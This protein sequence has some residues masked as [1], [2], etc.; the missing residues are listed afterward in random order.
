MVNFDKQNILNNIPGAVVVYKADATGEILYANKALIEL[1]ECKD[2][3]DFLNATN[4]SFRSAIVPDEL[5]Y[6][7]SNIERQMAQNRKKYDHIFFHILTK[8]S[9]AVYVEGYGKMVEDEEHGEVYYAF[10]AIPEVRAQYG[11][12]DSLTGLLNR[13]AFLEKSKRCEGS[14]HAVLYLDIRG[15]KLINQYYGSENGDNFLRKTAEVLERTFSDALIARFAAD[16]FVILCDDND[17]EGKI[18]KAYDRVLKLEESLKLKLDVGVY[19]S[20]N[21]EDINME[22]DYAKMACDSI[23]KDESKY[24]AYYTEALKKET[25]FHKYIADHIDDAIAN[26]HIQIYYQPVIRTMSGKLCG[27]EALARWIDPDLGLISPANF[28]PVLE[29][30]NI[31]YKLDMYVIEQVMEHLCS[32]RDAGKEVIPVSLNISR[33]DFDMFSP[34]EM[35]E[36]L[37]RKHRLL[38]EWVHIEV[39]ES[40]I[41][42]N[43]TMIKSEILKLREGGYEVWLDDFG[44][45]Y[46]SLNSLKDYPVDEIKFDMVFL[47]NFNERAKVILTSAVGM[48]KEL[49]IHTLAEGVETQEQFDFLKSIGCEKIQGYLYGRPEPYDDMMTAIQEKSIFEETPE[50]RNYYEKIG[51]TNIITDASIAVFDY[52]GSKFKTLYRSRNFGIVDNADNPDV[53]NGIDWIMNYDESPLRNAIRNLAEKA[54][55][56]GK[57]E[58]LDCVFSGRYYRAT[59]ECIASKNKGIA[60]L[61][62]LTDIT[63]KD[64]EEVNTEFN[65]VSRNIMN[66]FDTICVVNRTKR[67]I[68]AIRTEDASIPIGEEFPIEKSG[69]TRL[70]PLEKLYDPDRINLY[71]LLELTGEK[72]DTQRGVRSRFFRL[73]NEQGN[74]V[75][76]ESITFPITVPREASSAGDSVLLLCIRDA[77]TPPPETI[78]NQGKKNEL[79]YWKDAK[80]WKSLMEQCGIMFFWKD[81]ERRFLGCSRSFLDYFG[82]ESEDE[83]IGRTD[84]DMAWHIDDSLYKND[85]EKVLSTGISTLNIPGHV[86]KKGV[87]RNIFASKFPMY[88]DGEVSGLMGYFIDT[89]TLLPGDIA[90]KNSTYMDMATGLV[91]LRGFIMHLIQYEDNYLEYGEDY[92]M[93][94]LEIPVYYHMKKAYGKEVAECMIS[95]VADAI[96]EETRNGSLVA[97]TGKSHL[98]VIQKN[99]EHDVLRAHM[100]RYIRK[101]ESIH[102]VEGYK[103]TLYVKSSLVMTSDRNESVGIM[104]FITQNKEKIVQ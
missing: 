44:S 90:I 99:K 97:R 82:F 23:R 58:T 76:K 38:R 103:C 34:Y 55:R 40:A 16:H 80:R 42:D 26:G 96:R 63:F 68:R 35:I 77:L 100:D 45:G 62:T 31:I 75:K 7:E 25:D 46:S 19:I 84:E 89:D 66:L 3:E 17:I 4:G 56:S 41:S 13:R 64:K 87:P 53:E 69:L 52:D 54:G 91:N 57:V 32:V 50:T 70:F 94:V 81:R 83:I 10:L 36:G 14:R 49:G 6:V 72:E 86:I 33:R 12:A 61:T 24:F 8:N 88:N 59:M 85:E 104:E 47:R 5:E 78:E 92:G 28:V 51:K 2:F 11:E 65:N 1:F 20:E 73:R 15:F 18:A 37:V 48:A 79:V 29:D 102:Q 22:C 95:L 21:K 74:F 27:M 93:I 9:R 30:D 43:L 71:S 101:I 98:I 67:T 39:T 60:L